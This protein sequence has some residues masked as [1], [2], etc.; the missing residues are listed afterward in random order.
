MELFEERVK[1]KGVRKARWFFAW[2]V[3]K[4]FRP[5]IMRSM[6]GHHTL[7]H[8]GMLKNH[9][10]TALRLF[11]REKSYSLINLAGLVLGFTCCLMIFLFIKHELSYDSFHKEGERIYR[12]ASAYM[13][14][15][16]WEPYASNAWK[17]GELMKAQFPEIEALVR[18]MP[19]SEV[20]RY[21]NEVYRENRVAYVESNF[22]EV[23]T[24]PLLA[25]NESEALSGANKVV[26][27]RSMALK[28]FDL[29][30][31]LGKVLEL[32]DGRLQLKV[33]GIME[34]MPANSHFHFDF[35]IS[36]TTGKHLFPEAMFTHVGWDSQRVYFKASQGFDL[37]KMQSAFPDFIDTYLESGGWMTSQ[38]FELFIQ[39]LRDIHLKSN[40]GT[41]LEAN[42]NIKH[43]Y[44]FSIIAVFILIIACV[45]YMNLTAAR[46]LRRVK[47]VGIRKVLGA[48]RSNLI[49]RF[50]S[51][52][53]IMSAMAILIALL[54]TILLLPKFSQFA[55][56][57]IDGFMLL[58]P[59]VMVILFI[60]FVSVALLSGSYP[61][62][63]ISS[64]KGFKMVK[65]TSF[66]LL[67]RRGLVI[68]Q[69]VITIGLIAAT[70]IAYKQF[71][72]LLNK[73]LGMRKDLV[74]A[75]PL[76]TMKSDHFDAFRTELIANPS[77]SNAGLSNMKLPGWIFNSTDYKAQGVP[78]NE[79]A[80]KSMKIIRIDHDF[81]ETI[82]AEIMVGRD[83]SRDFASDLS[84]SLILNE[85]AVQQ[86]GWEEAVGKWVELEGKRF[87][88]IGIVRDFHFESLHR[89]IP[90]TIF[91]L[92]KDWYVWSYIKIQDQNISST[93]EHIEKVYEKFVTN[94]EFDY[95]FIDEDI[96]QQYSAEQKFSQ[97]FTIFSVL[98]IVIACLGTFGLISYSTDRKSKEIGIRKVLGASVRNVISLLIKEFVYLL[99][100]ASVITIPVTYYFI[101]GWMEG[102]IYR[103]TIGWEVFAFAS[104]LALGIAI[105]TTG[106]RAIQAA[107]A[108]PVDSL[109]DE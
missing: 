46:S 91:V 102:F 39:P 109:R 78:V 51:E 15:G 54:L 34:D 45:N 17:T 106:I 50:L 29:E 105:G 23:F 87:N 101:N 48:A 32:R 16:R 65:S 49:V 22:L 56:T 37:E 67:F 24:F 103:T 40:L 13:R 66:G 47:E 74:V 70:G 12:V 30:V 100:I 79:E 86:L 77:I 41:E 63:A 53:F 3:V 52:S 9:V 92:S 94:R 31:P 19:E 44:I 75:V 80:K 36:N 1:E 28:Y 33:S 73:E 25:G 7:N 83:F 97:L 60:L 18:I 93:L 11:E 88:V 107:L 61:A 58:K 69:F 43:I 81:L 76:Q 42:G 21:G 27:S 14:E 38:N 6:S 62:F 64:V 71:N 20:V 2:E 84:S 95:S 68:L 55:G 59:E 4:L 104:V 96:E 8:Y 82:G 35:L 89:K 99:L 72:Y 26:I 57:E 10:K 98:A 90:P 5:G 108:N 85:A